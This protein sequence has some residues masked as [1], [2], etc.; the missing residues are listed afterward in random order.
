MVRLARSIVVTS[1]WMKRVEN[2]FKD[3]VLSNKYPSTNVVTGL[4]FTPSYR[5]QRSEAEAPV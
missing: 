2:D 5:R 4:A 3:G 1:S